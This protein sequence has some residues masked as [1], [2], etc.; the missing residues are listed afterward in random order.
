MQSP[1]FTF[2]GEAVRY[3][4][5]TAEEVVGP[6]TFQMQR[7][8]DVEEAID[9]MFQELEARGCAD[10]LEDLCPYF[11]TVWPSA[12]VLAE[13]A[14][15]EGAFAFKGK[16]VL[17]LGCGLA[18]P[19]FVVSHLGADVLATD[20]H[21]DVPEFLSRNLAKNPGASIRYQHLDWKAPRSLKS[22][23]RY[24]WIL[25]SD[26]LYDS[27]QAETLVDFIVQNLARKGK[28]VITDPGRAYWS[29]LV[30]MAESAGL[31][32]TIE[33]REFPRDKGDK[34][35]VVFLSGT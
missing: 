27:N 8:A 26:V 35:V 3:R 34:C 9:A 33:E 31:Q 2:Q 32:V 12:R 23:T 21:P 29:R 30:K 10:L 1:E 28:A 16:R 25:A 7:I 6:L 4:V 11:G 15:D 22:A 13:W 17:E 24:D 14:W 5:A 18:L 20:L 19:S